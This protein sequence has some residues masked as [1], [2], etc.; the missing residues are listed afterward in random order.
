[1]FYNSLTALV[2]PSYMEGWG[3]PAVEAMA[4]GTP[5]AILADTVIPEGRSSSR[6]WRT[7]SSWRFEYVLRPGFAY[8]FAGGGVRFRP[9]TPARYMDWRNM[10]RLVFR[11]RHLHPKE[12]LLRLF[13]ESSAL[14]DGKRKF[15]TQ[16]V[17]FRGRPDWNEES[18]ELGRF[19][20]PSWFIAQNDLDPSRH[21][22]SL[23][24][25]LNIQFETPDLLIQHDSGT[26]EVAEIRLEGRWISELHLSMAI[27]L[28]WVLAGLLHGA[29]ML[30]GWRR[31]ALEEEGRATHAEEQA[32]MRSEFLATMSHEIRTPLNGIV[33]PAQM[34]R[35]SDLTR[36][37]RENVETILES[38]NH[39]LGILHDALDFSKMEAGKI[40]LERVPVSLARIMEAV[41]RTFE[42]KAMEKG[43]VLDCRITQELPLGI[44]GDPLRLRQILMNLVS[45][46]LKFTE[47]G[48]ISIEATRE[49]DPNG[50]PRVRFDVSDTGIGMD[51]AS[52]ERLFQRFSQLERSTTRRYGGTGLGL[53]IAQGLVNAMGGTIRVESALGKG[54]RFHFSFPLVDAAYDSSADEEE[55]DTAG[56]QGLRVLVVDDNRVNRRVARSLLLRLGC[57]VDDAGS[58]EEA[59]EH[60]AER[61]TEI[62]LMDCHM[63]DMDG[64]E[65][66]RILRGWSSDPSP[67]K[68]AAS[69]VPV[70]ALTADA[71]SDVR[72]RCLE[73]GMDDVLTKPLF[74]RDLAKALE[75]WKNV[76][77]GAERATQG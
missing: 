55:P 70:I 41:R 6:A 67:A 27:Q 26:M 39:L 22:S 66:T 51:P 21:T 49:T 73:A 52:Q 58:G 50:A 18:I 48:S 33:V 53:A 28:L 74:G 57:D 8:P 56:I 46:A 19:A 20:P 9:G 3:L 47:K 36:T 24:S 43:V 15:F 72:E 10:D 2:L 63:P 61:K 17:Q 29:R 12:P 40:E 71:L 34:L 45:N 37:Q 23:D 42:S 44:V 77:H 62:V 14:I 31:K 35:D 65:T 4:C 16:Q 69:T 1:L 60:L 38:G 25:I 59:L 13:V 7:D 30:V 64:F 68:R 76:R 11:F 54:S 5:V 75:T 32:Q